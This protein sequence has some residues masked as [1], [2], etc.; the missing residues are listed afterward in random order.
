MRIRRTVLVSV[1][2]LFSLGAASGAV[3]T[4]R[5]IAMFSGA[6]DKLDGF[7]GLLQSAG[8]VPGGKCRT[9]VKGVC[10]VPQA[11]EVN[12]KTGHCVKEVYN[13]KT[14]CVCKPNASRP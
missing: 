3:F 4:L 2:C 13:Y 8:F 7:P 14:Y 6:C 1:I 10:I 11:C 12:G 5:T 9:T